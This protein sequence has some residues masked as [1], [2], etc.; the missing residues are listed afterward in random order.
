VTPAVYFSSDV[1]NPDTARKFYSD[2]QMYTVGTPSTPDPELFMQPF[3]SWEIASKNNKWQG[4]NPMR[5]RSDAYDEAFRAAPGELD[6]VNRAALFI[7][8][9]DMVVEDVAV[10]PVVNRRWVAAMSHKLRATLSGWDN[11]F[12]NLKDW[13]RET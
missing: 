5:W 2:I 9:N 3:L 1:A 13:Y 11:D 6:P 4:R 12:W 7:K 10:I 8:M